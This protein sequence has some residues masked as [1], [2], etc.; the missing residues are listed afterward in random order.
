MPT[1][2]VRALAARRTTSAATT[3]MASADTRFAVAAEAPGST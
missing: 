3:T 1:A 2:L